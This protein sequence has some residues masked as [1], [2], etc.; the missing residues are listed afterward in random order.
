MRDLK[1]TVVRAAVDEARVAV[2]LG[3][4]ADR[5][6]LPPHGRAYRRRDALAVPRADVEVDVDM[7]STLDD[8]VYLWGLLVTGTDDDGY[9]PVVD[10]DTE[11]DEDAL[12]ARF[13][14]QIKGLRDAAARA[15][16]SFAAY[17]YSD[18]EQTRMKQ[19]SHAVAPGEVEGLLS[20]RQWH[21]VLKLV[22]STV[23]IGLPSS[24]LK[25]VAPL[26]G[27]SGYNEGDSGATSMLG[28]RRA[29]DPDLSDDEREVERVDLL[30]YNEAD[31]RAQRAVREWLSEEGGRF[32]PV[33]G[34]AG[35]FGVPT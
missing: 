24:S 11:P 29:V 9:R 15:G 5:T 6:P 19:R 22:G 32:A 12:F 34:L 26:A 13:W 14:S 18:A 17:C 20:G 25:V 7:E 28:H 27:F 2:T 16:R 10:W 1:T 35:R 8:A 33:E 4:A 30:R 21:D 3:A 31:V 23:V